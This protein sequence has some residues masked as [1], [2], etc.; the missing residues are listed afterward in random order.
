MGLDGVAHREGD[1]ASRWLEDA[2]QVPP[3][4]FDRD[5][6]QI[7]GVRVRIEG[8]EWRPLDVSVGIYQRLVVELWIF[9]ESQ[10]LSL[11]SVDAID[12]FFDELL[13]EQLGALLRL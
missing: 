1:E 6:L 4:H 2:K 13:G 12:E 7:E 3:T 11:L 5:R 10:F 8:K 9:F